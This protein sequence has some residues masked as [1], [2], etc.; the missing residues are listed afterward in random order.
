MPCEEDSCSTG[1]AHRSLVSCAVVCCRSVSRLGL[2]ECSANTVQ[3]LC[4]GHSLPRG[5]HLM[6][7]QSPDH[8]AG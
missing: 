1:Q 7:V 5:Q 2:N 3:L 4:C 6:S 8:C